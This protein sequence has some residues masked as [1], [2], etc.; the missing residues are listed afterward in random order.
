MRVEKLIDYT[1][2]SFLHFQMNKTII[3]LDPIHSL[4]G[5]TSQHVHV[6]GLAHNFDLEGSVSHTPHTTTVVWTQF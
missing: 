5:H 4:F 2:V 1:L 3:T 6:E